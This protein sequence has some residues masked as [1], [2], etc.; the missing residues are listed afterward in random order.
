MYMRKDNFP[1]YLTE[2]LDQISVTGQC[3]A[4]ELGRGERAHQ[5]ETCPFFFHNRKLHRKDHGAVFCDSVIFCDL[6]IFAN[7]LLKKH[8]PF[9]VMESYHS[10]ATRNSQLGELLV[11]HIH[12]QPMLS[13][14]TY[15]K[16][17]L[18][19]LNT[20]GCQMFGLSVSVNFFAVLKLMSK[21]LVKTVHMVF[22]ACRNHIC[23]S[24]RVQLPAFA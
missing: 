23:R 12:C 11:E 7:Q 16:K 20:I 4:S 15:Y 19:P 17:N 13:V 9:H 1:K 3:W 24:E 22:D 10:L 14:Q 6:V 21:W 18:S 8:Y 2:A 5:P